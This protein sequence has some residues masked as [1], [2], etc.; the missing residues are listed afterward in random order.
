MNEM[1]ESDFEVTLIA[2]NEKMS[3]FGAA[4]ELFYHFV[5]TEN[6]DDYDEIN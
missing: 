4:K 1:I 3:F 2:Q 6:T 5:F